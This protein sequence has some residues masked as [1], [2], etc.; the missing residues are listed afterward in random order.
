MY[1][2]ELHLH[3]KYSSGCGEMS[4]VDLISGYKAA[5]YSGIVVTD[6]YNRD[7]YH[8]KNIDPA[9]PGDRLTPFL[10][11]YYRM[12]E[13]GEKQGIKIYRG[14]ELRFDGSFNDY[15]FFNYP[16]SLLEDPEKVFT[17]GLSA[18]YEMH[19]GTD[20]L[21]IQAHPFRDHCTVS[22]PA[23]L[24]GME[25]ANMHPFHNS[26][27]YLAQR[28]AGGYPHLILTG[29]SDCHEPRHLAR[30]GILAEE[31]PEDDAALVALLRSGKYNIIN[32]DQP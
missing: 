30:G 24:D 16:D 4:A 27:N 14:A 9:S 6:H 11:G 10:E 13:E 25:I 1:K 32:P 12:K 15:L 3:T 18:F 21:L 19:K 20:S 5:G 23:Y 28:F 7:T 31:L 22:N 2:I 8:M 17:M 26:R 29:G